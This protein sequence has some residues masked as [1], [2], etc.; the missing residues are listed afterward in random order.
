M[1]KTNWTTEQVKQLESLRKEG[2]TAG[3][4]AAKLNKT[5]K[6]VQ[7]KIGIRC[8]AYILVL[9]IAGDDAQTVRTVII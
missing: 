2:L 4:I 9:D 7:V 1:A 8:G 3:E 6:A 5:L